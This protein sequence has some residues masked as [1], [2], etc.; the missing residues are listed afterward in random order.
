MESREYANNIKYC[1]SEL[2]TSGYVRKNT[3]ML[4]N[5]VGQAR[6]LLNNILT[7]NIDT[8]PDR[9]LEKIDDILQYELSN[10]HITI[11][12]SLPKIT[13]Y[14]ISLWQ[15]DITTLYID[16]IVNAA[17]VG[18]LGC[19]QPNHKCIDNV[20]HAKAGPRLR[21]ECKIILQSPNVS[22]ADTILTLGYNLPCR[23]VMHTVGPIYKNAVGNVAHD[24]KQLLSKCYVD[25]LNK[26]KDIRRQAI[27]FCCI[28]TGE[29]GYPN[30]EAA[31]VALMTVKHWMNTH[32]DYPVHVVFC[33]FKDEDRIIYE[34]L[35]KKIMV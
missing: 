10:K 17:N 31:F 21:E 1:L 29:Y 15:G 18:G 35:I 3:Q 5:N 20:I 28:S 23:Y 27:A 13:K 4:Y 6:E 34:K 25:C 19:F 22:T 26:L 24:N 2:S 9:I 16:A 30:E 8:L 14:K 7:T 12:Q 33:V 11:A 32:Q